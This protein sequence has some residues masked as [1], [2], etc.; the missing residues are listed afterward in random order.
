MAV[1]TSRQGLCP[2][3][4]AAAP[5]C[6]I[7]GQAARDSFIEVGEDG[8]FCERCYQVRPR[9]DVC[10]VPIGDTSW[11]LADGRQICD[12]CHQTAIYQPQRAQQLYGQTVAILERGLGLTLNIPTDFALVDRCQLQELQK[13]LEPRGN[14]DSEKTLGL[15]LRQGRRRGM[16]V[17]S[18]LPQILL[19]QVIAHEFGHAW[20]AENCPLLRSPLLRE[21]FAEWVAYKALQALG[22]A[23]KTAI[24]EARQGLYGDGL[25]A[26]LGVERTGGVAGVLAY[27][28]DGCPVGEEEA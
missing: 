16:Y 18:G 21:G 1:A 6:V 11:M 2:T 7:C 9:C 28:R 22:A 25:R 10:D 17:E 5:H 14:V 4:W 24:M 3:C 23:K 20:Q 12:R 13:G 8:P 15:Y 27:C 19:I 26:L